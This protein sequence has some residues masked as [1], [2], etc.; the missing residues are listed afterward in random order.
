MPGDVT[1]ELQNLVLAKVFQGL[2]WNARGPPY[3]RLKFGGRLRGFPT[4]AVDP[5][6]PRRLALLLYPRQP[7]GLSHWHWDLKAH[8]PES[9]KQTNTRAYRPGMPVAGVV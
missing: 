7:V 9:A 1:A 2:L 6:K 5:Q 3:A 4:V 8:P